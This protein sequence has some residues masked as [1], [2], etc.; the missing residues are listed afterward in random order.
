MM[1]RWH[2]R[3]SVLF[4]L[5]HIENADYA[6]VPDVII[7]ALNE[8]NRIFGSVDEASQKIDVL[9]YLHDAY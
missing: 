4:L 3:K 1:Y 7:N 2:L 8:W 9:S 5:E 6:I